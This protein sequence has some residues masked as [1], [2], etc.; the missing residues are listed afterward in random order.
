[1]KGLAGELKKDGIASNTLWP[2]TAV[3]TAAV[4]NLLGG[5]SSM[6]VSRTPEVLSDAAYV[7]L[8]SC[9]KT[10]TDKNYIVRLQSHT[11]LQ[12]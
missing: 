2:R 3:A 4:Q 1:M 8:T 5:D 12:I 6:K 11:S 9:S 7:I 10:T